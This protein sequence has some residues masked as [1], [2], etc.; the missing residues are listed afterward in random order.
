MTL[1]KRR[2]GHL[3][4]PHHDMLLELYASKDMSL[5]DVTIEFYR[6]TGIEAGIM[7]IR[8]YLR[9]N[10]IEVRGWKAQKPV[11][12][13][14][15][16]ATFHRKGSRH[17]LCERCFPFANKLNRFGRMGMT[18]EW[19][20]TRMNQCGICECPFP[21]PRKRHVDH[22]HVTNQVR[23]VLCEQCNHGLGNFKDDPELLTKAIDYLHSA[24]QQQLVVN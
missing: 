4:A 15:C 14:H 17:W 23:G 6:R 3:L 19:F 20:E 21:D 18:S 9:R 7:S 16:G 8:G 1:S 24:T 11:K 22:D 2:K 5:H 13:R 10:G 12:C